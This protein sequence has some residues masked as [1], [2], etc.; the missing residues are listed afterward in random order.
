[1]KYKGR[2]WPRINSEEKPCASIGFSINSD[3][4]IVTAIARARELIAFQITTKIAYSRICFVVD[5]AELL[6]EGNWTEISI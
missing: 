3:L 4:S 5:R 1:M 2:Y 6:I